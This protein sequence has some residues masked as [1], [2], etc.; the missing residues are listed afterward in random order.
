MRWFFTIFGTVVGVLFLGFVGWIVTRVMHWDGANMWVGRIMIW[1][2]Y[3]VAVVMSYVAFV[4]AWHTWERVTGRMEL[5][6]AARL[7]AE[8]QALPPR[9]E[10]PDA[11]G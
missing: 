1:D 8:G 7:Q 10:P 9:P 6:E 2:L 11:R 5:G 4:G 3:A